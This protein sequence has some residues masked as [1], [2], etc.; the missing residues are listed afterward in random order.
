MRSVQKALQFVAPGQDVLVSADV[1][2]IRGAERIV[3]PGQG[4]IN[5][6]MRALDDRSLAGAINHALD[7]LP[8]LGICLGL[9]ALFAESEE[10]GGVQC[11]GRMAGRVRH[12]DAITHGAQSAH[13]GAHKIPHMGWNTVHQK[14]PHPV[15]DGIDDAERFYFVHSYFV[16][17][18]NSQDV[19]GTTDYGETFTSAVARDNVFATQFHP[20]KS[21]E[22]GLTLLKN[23]CSW[24]P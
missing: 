19:V 20:E 2:D 17:S 18:D 9:Q 24:N 16:E 5:T 3:L 7:N 10:G 1:A 13:G 6:W 15:W 14:Q 4:A 22:A 21:A 23:F 11:L 12:F 8:V